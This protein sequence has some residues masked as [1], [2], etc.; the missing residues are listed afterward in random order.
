MGHSRQGTVYKFAIGFDMR[1]NQ[2]EPNKCSEGIGQDGGEA[3]PCHVKRSTP[4]RPNDIRESIISVSQ[5]E[6]KHAVAWRGSLCEGIQHVP[7]SPAHPGKFCSWASL[8]QDIWA[9]LG[10]P[11]IPN[12]SPHRAPGRGHPVP[13]VDPVVPP[14]GGH[15]GH[16]RRPAC[17]QFGLCCC[18]PDR[19]ANSPDFVHFAYER[20]LQRHISPPPPPPFALLGCLVLRSTLQWQFSMDFL[21]ALLLG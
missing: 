12:T 13:A 8:D 9:G 20:M 11:W 5:T 3:S 17:E 18:I 4:F 6:C 2:Y 19:C 7:L 1:G 21:K 10:R 14:V 15:A 16:R